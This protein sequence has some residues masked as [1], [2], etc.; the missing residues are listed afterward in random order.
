MRKIIILLLLTISTTALAVIAKPGCGVYGDEY[1]HYRLDAN[2]NQIE[3]ASTIPQNSIHPRKSPQIS[4]TFPTKGKVKSLVILVNFSDLAFTI[5]DANTAFTNMLNQKGYSANKGTGSAKDY[6]LASS[7]NQFEPTFDVYGPVTLSRPSSYYDTH[8][9]QMVIDACDSLEHIIDWDAYDVNDDGDVDNIFIYYAGHNEAEG[10]P[11]ESIWPHRSFVYTEQGGSFIRYYYIG[12]SGKRR[13]LWDYACTSELTG[14]SGKTMC[15]IGTFCHEF[16]HVLGL[17][18]LYNTKQSDVYT[19]GEWDLMCTGNYNNDGRTPPS[20]SAFERFILGWITPMQLSGS[21]DR[22]LEPIETGNKAYLIADT[23]HN[24]TALNPNPK[25]YWLLENRQKVGW[26]QPSGCIPGSG[27]LISH[28]SWDG[29]KWENNTPNNSTPL[30]Y[31]ICEAYNPTPTYSSA[32]D[33]FPGTGH[34]TQF[35]PQSTSGKKLSE[36]QLENIRITKETNIAFHY[37]P[38]DGSGFQISKLSSDTIITE[39]VIKPTKYEIATINI[40]GKK[41]CDSTLTIRVS[42]T[43]FTMSTDGKNFSRQTITD[44]VLP[45]STYQKTIYVRYEPLQLCKTASCYIYVSL[46]NEIH[47]AQVSLFGKSIR[48]KLIVPVNATDATDPTPYSFVAQWEH[49][50]DA[51]LYYLTL[52]TIKDEPCTTKETLNKTLSQESDSYQTAYSML[53]IEQCKLNYSQF[54]DRQEGDGYLILEG[55]NK[56]QWSRVDSIHT[57]TV[58]FTTSKDYKFSSEQSYH[59]LR[60]TFYPSHKNVKVRINYIELTTLQTPEYIYSGDQCI[61]DAV[62][63]TLLLTG[64]KPSTSYFYCLTCSESKGCTTN[65]TEP[66]NIIHTQT[67]PG[68]TQTN[69]QFTILYQN[70]E[71]WAYLPY[72]AENNSQ[73]LIFSS[74][75]RLVKEVPIPASE[76][77][78][79]IPSYDLIKGQIYH[80]KYLTGSSMK[81]KQLWSKFLY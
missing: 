37:G 42:G 26:D 34:I 79:Q 13:W 74:D 18:D 67:L 11:T 55:K 80:V 58:T 39:M 32:S 14:A 72:P 20:L 4:T 54:Y 50:S 2:H 53:P 7:M 19:V 46:K 71:V 27:L 6:F 17:D 29:N 65:T 1:Y 47:Q 43:R 5:P 21:V 25:E 57:R 49:Q 61:I 44:S 51:E 64:L 8:C 60:T 16:S 9:A 45:D 41:L 31:D 35:V 30:L 59:T 22:D 23:T 70:G 81:R 40:T 78:V 33:L 52:F 36:K 77:H 28:I 3:I 15:G 12:K 10:G 76:V 62:E 69:K 48:E 68:T 38:N 73:F 63:D 75:G 66:G 56:D 24:M